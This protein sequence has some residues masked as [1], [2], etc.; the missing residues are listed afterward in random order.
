MFLS[1]RLSENGRLEARICPG[2]ALVTVEKEECVEREW[3][4]HRGHSGLWVLLLYAATWP[5]IER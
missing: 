2:F 1:Q 3:S 4:S 5:I